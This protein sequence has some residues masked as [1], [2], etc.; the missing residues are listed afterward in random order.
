MH[1]F[2]LFI[3]HLSFIQVL[4][5]SL[6]SSLCLRSII[7]RLLLPLTALQVSVVEHYLSGIL[8]LF[9]HFL[10][11]QPAVAHVSF[12]YYVPNDF[13]NM[14]YL[15]VVSER[16]PWPLVNLQVSRQCDE[17]TVN[18]TICEALFSRLFWAIPDNMVHVNTQA[19]VAP[20]QRYLDACLMTTS[21]SLI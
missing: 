11:I 12:S 21:P 13:P 15:F 10:C 7:F 20:V 5:I 1:Y 2:I 16:Y 8:S 17:Y 6:T 4:S 3:T 14:M 9:V 19:M 18:S